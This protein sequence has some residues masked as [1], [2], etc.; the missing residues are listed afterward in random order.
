[1]CVLEAAD[2]V[3]LWNGKPPRGAGVLL[4]RVKAGVESE[5]HACLGESCSLRL[6]HNRAKTKK[7]PSK[8]ACSDYFSNASI[9]QVGFSTYYSSMIIR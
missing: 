1:M 6:Q 3:V 7:V 5:M 8:Q 2:F 9:I 4:G